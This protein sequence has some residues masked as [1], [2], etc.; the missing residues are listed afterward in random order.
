[1]GREEMRAGDSERQAVAD[2]L[3]V[4]LDEGRL[5][6]HE[7]D[8]RLQQA[9]AAKTYGDLDGL[10]TDLPGVIPA[11]RSRLE[12]RQQPATPSAASGVDGKGKDG[13]RPF[14]AS[15]SGVVLVCVVIWAMSC[16]GSGEFVYFWPG[17]MLIPLLFGLIGRITGRNR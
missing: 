17:W 4:A 5:D 3:K 14:L 12:P 7:Y 9:Y 15:Y 13:G 11:Q 16:L 2:Q 6:L 1:M 10:V 8:E